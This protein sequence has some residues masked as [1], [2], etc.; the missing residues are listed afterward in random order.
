[1]VL[2]H[3][4]QQISELVL[5]VVNVPTTTAQLR[6][7][8]VSGGR[9]YG[10]PFPDT[11]MSITSQTNNKWIFLVHHIPSRACSKRYI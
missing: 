10:H 4:S 6:P 1:M 2:T 8:L 7:F 5:G 11:Q 3:F 9:I